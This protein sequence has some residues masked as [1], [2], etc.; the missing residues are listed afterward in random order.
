MQRMIRMIWIPLIRWYISQ[1]SI[2]R[3]G[4]RASNWVYKYGYMRTENL[5]YSTSVTLLPLHRYAYEYC[6]SAGNS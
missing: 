3:S 5:L 2:Q 4:F 1:S 6:T